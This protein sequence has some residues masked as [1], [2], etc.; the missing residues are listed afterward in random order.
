MQPL[1]NLVD[2]RIMFPVLQRLIECLCAELEASGGPSLCYCGMVV[3]DI[4]PLEL[5]KC[6]PGGCGGVAWIRPMQ[7]FSSTEF[8]APDEAPSC[9]AVLA[10]P[11]EI[12]VARCYPRGDIKKPMNPQDMFEAARLYMSDMQAMRRA[13]K[14]C[15][16]D[17]SF[18]GSYALGTWEPIPASAGVS[19]GTW[20]VVI[21]PEV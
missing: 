21:R 17:A 19:G 12:G 6:G 2:D 18:Q 14:C 9:V 11:V 3:G 8:P 15:L 20:T 4:M 1:P 16:A 7:A 5:T 13:V 10:M